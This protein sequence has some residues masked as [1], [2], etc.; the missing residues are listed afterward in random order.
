MVKWIKKMYGFTLLELLVVI[1]IIAMLSSILLPALSKAREKGRQSVC[2]SNLKQLTLAFIMYKND[3]DGWYPPACADSG[4]GNPDLHRWHGERINT[5][6]PFIISEQTPIYPYLKNKEIRACP[7]FKKYLTTGVSAFE[8][9][10]G[11]YGYNSQFVGGD[12]MSDFQSP[13]KDK[14]IK[15]PSD[16]IMLTDCAFLSNDGAGNIIEYSFVIAPRWETY[17]YDFSPS[18]HFRHNEFANVAFCDGHVESKRMDSSHGD[19]Y[20]YTEDDFRNNNIGFVGTDNTLY[21]RE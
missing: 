14:D 2:I 1:A 3:N 21:D 11:G 15:N 19:C 5:S 18:I 10:C 16:T 13:A 17:S 20:G 7:S 4:W 9:G 8:A 12:S 6:S